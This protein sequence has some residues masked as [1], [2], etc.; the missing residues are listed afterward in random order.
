MFFYILIWYIA[1]I[2]EEDLIFREYWWDDWYSHKYT[3]TKL[4]EGTLLAVL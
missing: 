4:K 2:Y 1:G 3:K